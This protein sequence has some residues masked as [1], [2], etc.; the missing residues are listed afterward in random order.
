MLKIVESPKD[1]NILL[2]ASIKDN[3]YRNNFG[4]QISADREFSERYL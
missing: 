1:E 2:I 4:G 3:E